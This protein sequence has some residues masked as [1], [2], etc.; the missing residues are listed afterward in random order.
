MRTRQMFTLIGLLLALPLAAL[1]A[2]PFGQHFSAATTNVVVVVADPDANSHP[3]F[4][5][6]IF[7]DADVTVSAATGWVR[8][9]NHGAF[10]GADSVTTVPAG[11]LVRS[12]FQAKLL[13]IKRLGSTDGDVHWYQ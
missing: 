4:T 9:N 2:G 13:F 1:A 6:V 7:P 3:S 11:M 5:D 8:L 12:D 10:A